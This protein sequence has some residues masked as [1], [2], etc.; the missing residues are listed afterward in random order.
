MGKPQ[1]FCERYFDQPFSLA[2]A[3]ETHERVLHL[4]QNNGPDRCLFSFGVTAGDSTAGKAAFVRCFSMEIRK[5][6]HPG[7][8]PTVEGM[9]GCPQGIHK[10][11]RLTDDRGVVTVAVPHPSTRD[12]VSLL[13]V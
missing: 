8:K 12:K 10:M 7:A 1:A 9:K 2:A 13:G 3:A 6:D 5:R 11:Y 4:R